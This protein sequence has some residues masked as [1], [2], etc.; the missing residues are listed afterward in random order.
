MQQQ[1][2]D[3]EVLESQS[4]SGDYLAVIAATEALRLLLLSPCVW[5][6]G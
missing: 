5:A 1:V 3:A 6:A 2:D 4:Q